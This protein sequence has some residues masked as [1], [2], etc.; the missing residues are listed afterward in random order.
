MSDPRSV[1][2]RT[3]VEV[4]AALGVVASLVFVGVEIRQNAEATRAAT[5]LQL[6][7]DWVQLNLTQAENP[8]LFEATE[9]VNTVGFENADP[10]SQ[11]QAIAVYRAI[12]HNWSN[13]YYQYRIGTLEDEQWLPLLRDMEFESGNEHLWLMWDRWDHVFDDPFRTLMDSLK[14]ANF[15]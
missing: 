9:L 2:K 4:V 14:V 15:D 3:M 12:I 11:F 10:R 13:A 7:A 6:K 5:V 8:E 1:D